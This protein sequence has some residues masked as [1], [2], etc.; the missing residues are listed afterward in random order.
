MKKVEVIKVMNIRSDD[1]D[2]VVSKLKKEKMRNVEI[3][4]ASSVMPCCS[5]GDQWSDGGGVVR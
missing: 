1:R 5:C 4:T 2:L 3:K